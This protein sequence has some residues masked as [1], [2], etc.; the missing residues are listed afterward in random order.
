[1]HVF[2]LSAVAE[3]RRAAREREAAAERARPVVARMKRVRERPRRAAKPA[4]REG[5]EGVWR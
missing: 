3:D 2:D 4:T 1:M 5:I